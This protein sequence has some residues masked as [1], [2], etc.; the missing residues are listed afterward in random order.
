M[1][2][3][4]VLKQRLPIK[5]NDLVDYTRALG[6]VLL[7][8]PNRYRKLLKKGDRDTGA[9][10]AVAVSAAIA[11]QEADWPDANG[12]LPI[13]LQASIDNDWCIAWTSVAQKTHTTS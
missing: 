4:D 11:M 9:E 13:G 12:Y 5:G 10:F 6:L 3:D 2:F 8:A 7:R 1:T